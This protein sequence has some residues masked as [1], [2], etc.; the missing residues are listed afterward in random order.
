MMNEKE[1]LDYAIVGGGVS[2]IYTGLRLLEGNGPKPRVALFESSDALGGRL[3]SV[4]PPGIPD[5]RVELGG[6][7]FISKAQPLVTALVDHLGLATEP[8][9]ADQPQNIAHLRGRVLRQFELTDAS[10]VPYDLDPDERGPEALSNL[11]ATAAMRILRQTIHD[12]LGK[13]I[14]HWGQLTELSDDEWRTIA[15]KGTWDGVPLFTLPLRYLML[16]AISHEA[17]NLAQDASGYDSILHTW[18]G[19]DGFGWNIGDY[20]PS[21]QYLHVKD[22]Y[23]RVPLEMARRF[24]QAGGV[25]ELNS[26]LAR[27]TRPDPESPIRLR[28]QGPDGRR[29][30]FANHLILAMPRRSIELIDQ[31][32]PVLARANRDVHEL[33]G[34]VTPIPLFKV[35]LCYTRAWWEDLPPV[36][37]GNGPARIEAGK[38]VTDLPVR[39]CYYWK[40]NPA[41]GHAV[42]LIY[43][44]GVALDYWAGLRET[45]GET[46][47]HDPTVLGHEFDAPDWA[48]YPAPRRMVDEVHRQLVAMHGNPPDVPMPYTAAYRDWGEDPYGGGAC[49][50]P[51]GVK[52]YEVADRILQPKP[53]CPVYICGDAYSHAQGWVEGALATAEAVLQKHLGMAPPGWLENGPSGLGQPGINHINVVTRDLQGTAAF[54]CDNFG[55]SAGKA[56]TMKGHWVDELTGYEGAEATFV[57]LALNGDSG[58]TMIALLKY[59]NPPTPAPPNSNPRLDEP[60]YRHIGFTVADVD[61]LYAKLKDRYQFFSAPVVSEEM[62]VKTVYFRGPESIVVQLTQHL[63]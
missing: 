16:Q 2:G 26:R 45:G 54:F 3:C 63:P 43:D 61:A 35:A 62:R 5:A 19:A 38:S 48:K 52:S 30:V 50:W 15:E 28:I 42:V 7:R 1:I 32:G 23:E 58:A 34:S 47:P 11:T 60:G 59:L 18:S 33:I 8:L 21:V 13:T 4:T 46:W 41:N 24:S 37:A 27:F 36:D 56:L 55:F 9:A 44:D 51:V 39:Q 20:G 17:W 22:G 31:K 6:M 49:F 12:L 14:L 10:K 40:V 53:G 29:E 25:V 57:P